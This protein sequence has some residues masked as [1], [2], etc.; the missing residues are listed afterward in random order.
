M[1]QNVSFKLI[2]PVE[3]PL[4]TRAS[5]RTLESLD[6]IMNQLMPLEL[7]SPVE[8]G[9]ADFACKRLLTGMNHKVHLEIVGSLE[10]LV[11]ELAREGTHTVGQLVPPEVALA[12]KHLG[13][14]LARVVVR[15]GRRVVL[16]CLCRRVPI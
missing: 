7:I 15:S 5:V 1:S 4:A 12:G 10:R 14:L 13:T 3:L 11:A 8:G 16:Q 6:G 2:G 9:I